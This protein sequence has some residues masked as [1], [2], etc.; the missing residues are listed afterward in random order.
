MRDAILDHSV[1]EAE[2]LLPLLQR[3]PVPELGPLVYEPL[4]R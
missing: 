2:L 1:R 4:S 3:V